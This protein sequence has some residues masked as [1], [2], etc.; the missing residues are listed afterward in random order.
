MLE[1]RIGAGAMSVVYRGINQRDGKPVAIKIM[2]RSWAD[3]EEL[4][5]RFGR[6]IRTCMNLNHKNIIKVFAGGTLSTGEPYL[7]MEFLQGKLLEEL[8]ETQSILDPAR[9]LHLVCEAANGLAQAH[10]QGYVHRDIK[11]QNLMVV[12]GPFNQERLKVL[13]FGV[14]KLSDAMQIYEK[15]ATAPGDVLGTPLYMSPEQVLGKKIDGRSDIYSLGCVLYQCLCGKPAIAGNGAIEIMKNQLDWLPPHLNYYSPRKLPDELNT[16]VQKAIAKMP[17][18]RYANMSEFAAAI[19]NISAP[20][21]LNRVV[22]L[23]SILTTVRQKVA[24]AAAGG[25]HKKKTRS[26]RK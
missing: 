8:M 13:D 12:R 10:K 14:A 24:V 18:D 3:E 26:R 17:E 20:S 2:R 7:V 23:S 21:A 19:K 1:E 16:L 11:P 4:N 6:E 9:A 15:F 25:S 5:A 22:N